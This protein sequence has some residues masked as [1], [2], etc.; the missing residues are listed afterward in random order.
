VSRTLT[1]LEEEAA[2]ALPTSRRVVLRN[3]SALSRLNA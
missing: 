3:R 1:Q 2:I